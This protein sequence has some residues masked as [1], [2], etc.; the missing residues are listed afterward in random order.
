MTL[1]LRLIEGDAGAFTIAIRA[2][3]YQ[4]KV[5]IVFVHMFGSNDDCYAPV[6]RYATILHCVGFFGVWFDTRM[7]QRSAV[8]DLSCIEYI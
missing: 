4:N 5:C 2:S 8:G 1:Q 6:S 3:H 7:I